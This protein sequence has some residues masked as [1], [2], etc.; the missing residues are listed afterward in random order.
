M[1][2]VVLVPWKLH[3]PVTPS[4]LVH[5]SPEVV[6]GFFMCGGAD[7]QIPSHLTFLALTVV[8]RGALYFKGFEHTYYLF[9]C[10]PVGRIPRRID[11]VRR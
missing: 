1:F 9:V 5:N 6:V 8:P 4:N 2:C 3:T 7:G 10:L 11:V